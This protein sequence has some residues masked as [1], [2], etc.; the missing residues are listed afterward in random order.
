MWE[1]LVPRDTTLEAARVQWAV[2]RAMTGEQRLRMV[3]E[4]NEEMRELLL[5]GLRTRHPEFNDDQLRLAAIRLTL[6]EE[7]F[8]KAYPLV[9]L[10]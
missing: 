2:L 5:A 9:K 8:R 6:G 7:L 4:M 3:F 10:P 1:L